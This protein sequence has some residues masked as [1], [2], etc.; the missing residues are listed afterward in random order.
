MVSNADVV[1]TLERI[2]DLLEIRGENAFKA[3]A[4]RQAAV[5]VDNIGRPLPE[6]A[7]SHGGL[8]SVDGFGAA[9]AGKLQ[10]LLETGRSSYLER[11]ETEVPPTLVDILALP[12]VGPRTVAMLWRDA[13]ITTVDELEMAARNGGLEHLPRLGART[14]GN[15]RNALDARERRGGTAASRR[16]RDGVAPLAE[17]LCAALGSHPAALRV[18]PAGSFRR[19]RSTCGD[20]DVL[21]ATDH[22]VDLLVS[23]AALPQV[24]RVLARGTTKSSVQV[25]GGFQV[26]CRAVP[27]VSFGAALQYFTGSQ[28]HNVRLR[29]RALRLGLTLNEYGVFRVDDGTRIAGETEHDVYAAIGLPWI[30]PG[31]R[32]DP[33]EIE[34]V[35]HTTA[36]VTE[37]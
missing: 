8:R 37:A 19:G 29:G 32:E 30:P 24:E 14:V 36:V 25:D 5:Q 1:R 17:S 16:D 3:R 34:L 18:E 11:L 35:A 22:A 28:A 4:Y 9:I 23:F 21:V 20:L 6:V 13:G 7:A 26:D 33:N 2:A 31:R 10:E 12:G 27:P 15:L